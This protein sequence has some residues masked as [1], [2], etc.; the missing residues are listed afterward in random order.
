M[1]IFRTH[2]EYTVTFNVPGPKRCSTDYYQT[3]AQFN[4][5]VY[6]GKTGYNKV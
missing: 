5:N 4:Q 3:L 6:Q 1:F 2:L